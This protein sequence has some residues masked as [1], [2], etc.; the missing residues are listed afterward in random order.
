MGPATSHQI[1]FPAP[2]NLFNNLT[3]RLVNGTAPDCSFIVESIKD[4]TFS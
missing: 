3:Y 1:E 4:S 2:C